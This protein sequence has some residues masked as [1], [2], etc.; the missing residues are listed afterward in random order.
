M[1]FLVRFRTSS[2]ERPERR[3]A[4]PEG[5]T[6]LEATRSVGLP[7]ARACDGGGLCARCGIEILEGGEALEPASPAEQIA[8]QR[9]RVPLE[10]RLACQVAVRGPL[11]VT[12]GYW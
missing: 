6:L 3:L 9:N 7:I 1:P 5:T 2:S 8:K 11:E 10:L 12:A 4:V